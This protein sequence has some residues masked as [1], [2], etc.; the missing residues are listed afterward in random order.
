M[1]RPPS[2]KCF[3]L[4]NPLTRARMVTS[5]RRVVP[6]GLTTIGTVICRAATTT[7][8][9][10]AGSCGGSPVELQPLPSSIIAA[11]RL[12]ITADRAIRRRDPHDDHVMDWALP[13]IDRDSTGHEML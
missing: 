1:T 8:R 6:I 3:S 10:R 2:W 11:A 7:T 4:R 12:H 9:G 13:A 5:S